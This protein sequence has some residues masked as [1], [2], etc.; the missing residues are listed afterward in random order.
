MNSK[1]YRNIIIEA[2]LNFNN[3]NI[4]AILSLMCNDVLWPNG[5][6]G[7]ILKGHSEVR[8]YWTRQWKSINPSVDP[9]AIKAREKDKYEVVVHQVIK[10]LT[11]KLLSDIIVKHIYQFENGLIKSMEIEKP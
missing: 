7:G 2:Y 8:D 3:R 5:W 6:E 9:V 11:G 10:D 1:N 4:K